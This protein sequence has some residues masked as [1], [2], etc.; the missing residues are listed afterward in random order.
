MHPR[1]VMVTLV[2]LGLGLGLGFAGAVLAGEADKER[3]TAWSPIVYPMQRLP[4]V[5]SHGRHLARGTQCAACHPAATTSRSAVD[6][7]IPTEAACRACHPIDRAEPELVVPGAP[8]VACRTCHPDYVPGAP[9]AQIYLTPPPLKFDHSAHRAAPCESCHGDMRSVAL[10]TTQQLP[11]MAACLRCHT[12]GTEER[13][14][15][16]CHLARLGGL[17]ETQ[18]AHGTLVPSHDGLG[19]SH[20]PGFKDHHTQEA[21]QVGA[22]CL[23]CHDRSECVACHQGVVKPMDF[24][25]GNY[26][27]THAVEARRGKPDCSA[28]HRVQS[29]CVGCHEREGI[30]ARGDTPYRS[31]DPDRAFHPPGWA[32]GGGGLNLHAREARRNITSCASCHRESDCLSCHSAQPGTLHASP[33][34]AGWR[35]SARCKALDRGNRRMCLRC[36]I[37]QDEVG[38][39]WTAR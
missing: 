36:H 25:A 7:L 22:T 9:V 35:G 17:I 3:A 8:P 29:F 28:C 2:V 33:H 5:F 30:G 19:D 34:P 18:F 13:H 23:V 12:R 16:D 1:I 32:S 38:C 14:C 11:T 31:N 6:T 26:L 39:N 37:A 21:R 4:L 10:A 24:H 27:L 15:T 20:G